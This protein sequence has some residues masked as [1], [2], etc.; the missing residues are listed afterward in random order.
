MSDIIITNI[1]ETPVPITNT[2]VNQYYTPL[3]CSFE[4]KNT[5]PEV[6]NG[7]IRVLGYEMEGYSF[8]VEHDDIRITSGDVNIMEIIYN[9]KLAALRYDITDADLDIELY[10]D[11]H[12]VENAAKLVTFSDLKYKSKNVPDIAL[13]HPDSQIIYLNPGDRLQIKTIKVIKGINNIRF[14]NI[15]APRIFPLDR[16]V[17]P[18]FTPNNISAFEDMTSV[19]NPIH[20]LVS[21]EIPTARPEQR[22]VTKKLII[23]ACDIIL[24]RLEKLQ[25]M[26]KNESIEIV[27]KHNEISFQT[28]ETNTI[29]KLLERFCVEKLKT[30]KSVVSIIIY[31]DDKFMF[32][33]II[34]EPMRSFMYIIEECKKV[35][36]AIKKLVLI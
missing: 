26:I 15:S 7:I 34:E 36:A 33:L 10:I 24:M 3:D 11:M 29:A 21:F 28:V 19:S 35:Y 2:N 23:I 1:I 27:L 20:H 8:D 13:T 31:P 25:H 12:N 16:K 6:P 14:N 17:I 4:I 22:N 9:I 30:L 32:S 5:P 18:Y